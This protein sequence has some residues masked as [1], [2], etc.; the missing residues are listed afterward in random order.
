MPLVLDG[1]LATR[2]EAR[3]HDLGG[4]LWSARLLLEDP[5]E[6]T[7]AHAD[8]ADAGAQIATTASYQ[9]SF[10]GLARL[11]IDAAGTAHLLRRSVAVARAAGSSAAGAGWVAA[12]IGP[13]GATLADGSE[14][15]GRYAVPGTAVAGAA[16]G[17]L[18]RFLAGWHRR[19]LTALLD[20]EPSGW[21][22]VLAL[23][24]IP[25]LAEVEAL[26]EVLADPAVHRGIPAWL[27]VT[28]AGDALRSGEP[29]AAAFTL[30]RDCDAVLAVGVN[31]TDPADAA[32]LVPL[33][34][35]HSGKPVVVYPNSGERWDAVG[36]RW[37]GP[38]AFAAGSVRRWVTDGAR[39]VGGCCRV[40]PAEIAALAAALRD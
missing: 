18:R 37:T 23:E 21:P 7:A 1:G 12:S 8:F 26:V 28:C 10:E 19:R 13:Y 14:Y 30:A 20:T 11:G 25:C 35:E 17:P 5:G 16:G 34:A 39:L 22:D 4:E 9:V 29:A 2:L 31:C 3:G 32:A 24:T 36:R 40:G 15:T 27:A 38:A 6:V 33:A